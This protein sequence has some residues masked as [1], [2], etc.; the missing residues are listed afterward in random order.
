MFN[1][2]E[3]QVCCAQSNPGDYVGSYR[4]LCGN[5]E[6]G[7]CIFTTDFHTVGTNVS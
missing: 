5:A 1:C 3:T 4:A 7:H 6:A 2:G